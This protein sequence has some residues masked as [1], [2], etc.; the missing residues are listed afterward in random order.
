MSEILHKIP[1]GVIGVGHLGQH[2]ARILSEIP[3]SSLKG[4]VDADPKRGE[5]IAKQEIN[6]DQL[7]EAGK[8]IGNVKL[9]AKIISGEDLASLRA[10]TD[11]IRPKVKQSVLAL[12]GTKD[13]KVHT[14]IAL[15]EDLA[16]S[17]LDARKI[18]EELSPYLEGNAGGRKTWAQGGGR[19]VAGLDK[20]M[21][22]LPSIIQKG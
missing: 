6:I 13:S 3:S 14:V 21:D 22:A 8:K 19:N 11:Q 5:K 15:T 7:I 4:I 10:L 18:A 16:D 17:S 12:F 9:I 20:A 2:H 1:M